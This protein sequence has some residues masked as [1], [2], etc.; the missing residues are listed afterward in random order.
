[1]KRAELKRRTAASKPPR[2]STVNQRALSKT[3]RRLY[4]LSTTLFVPVALCVALEL[5]LRVAGVG[6]STRFFVPDPS[7]GAGYLKENPKFGWRFFPPEI[8]RTPDPIRLSA[9]KQPG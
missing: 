6:Y 3:R 4:A 5:T 7:R 1:M 2:P 9:H 8:A